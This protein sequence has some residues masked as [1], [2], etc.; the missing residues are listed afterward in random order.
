VDETVSIESRMERGQFAARVAM[1][2]LEADLVV[3]ADG[4]VASGSIPMGVASLEVERVY[5]GGAF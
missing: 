4:S 3:E 2:G 1:G 5:V